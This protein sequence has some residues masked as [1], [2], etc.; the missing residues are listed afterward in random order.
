MVMRTVV[1]TQ[2]STGREIG[3]GI[4]QF[5]GSATVLG[6]PDAIQEAYEAEGILDM[7]GLAGKRGETV[8]LERG[9]DFLNVLLADWQRPQVGLAEE[10][11]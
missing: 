10:R 11:S 8:P 2:P 5:D 9:N 4:L 3:R 6:F 1:I 7:L